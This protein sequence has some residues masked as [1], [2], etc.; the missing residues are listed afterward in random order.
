[1]E[2]SRRDSTAHRIEMVEY[3][4]QDQ[5]RWSFG[6]ENPN[7]AAALIASLL[8]LLWIA[9]QAAWGI[10]RPQLKWPL[11]IFG[12]IAMVAGWWM[13]FMTYSRG[14]IVAAMAGFLYLGWREREILLA[15]E[16]RGRLAVCTLTALA[17]AGL[18]AGTNA[19]ERSTQWVAKREGSVVNRFEIWRGGLEMI[20]Q[21]PQGVGRGKS[22]EFYMQW[23]QPL[24]S[25]TRYRTLVNSY[26][27]FAAE[28]GLAVF[29][30]AAFAVAALWIGT[31]SHSGM[32]PSTM[33]GLRGS[34]VAFA[35]AG[36]F[37]TTMEEW[38][39]WIVPFVC[40]VALVPLAIQHNEHQPWRRIGATAAGLGLGAVA[41]IYLA[42]LDATY[43][44]P[45]R[46]G[47]NE[48]TVQ[49]K[50]VHATPKQRY[51]VW[52]DDIVLG[53]DYGKLLRRLTLKQSAVVRVADI[54]PEKDE[55][56]IIAGEAASRLP[57]SGL[58]RNLVMIAP[59]RIDVATAAH[60]L[61]TASSVALLIPS[62]DDDGR[63]A[64]WKEAALAANI[65]PREIQGV[66]S[67]VESA[68]DGILWQVNAG[69][70]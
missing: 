26:L 70:R 27:T 39:L 18:F 8:P 19:A 2:A 10:K 7:K 47:I 13:L 52:S 14:G 58:D 36:V 29:G 32:Q 12:G 67:Q 35:V 49:I 22:G 43:G 4:F 20:A 41:V 3:Y 9:A 61:S 69:N 50:P 21:I 5:L 64:L 44:E 60:V 24:N 65:Q 46:I 25:T 59:A 31:R 48:G 30:C 1:M 42:G 23:F 66:G 62:F 11:V 37:S 33:T 17:V 15:R 16:N 38:T 34:L 56:L 40:I 28:Q 55:T 63:V 57:S 54:Q 45:L 51:L 68:W 53:G 6:F